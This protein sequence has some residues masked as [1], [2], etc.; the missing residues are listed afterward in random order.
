MNSKSYNWESSAFGRILQGLAE[1]FTMTDWSWVKAQVEPLVMTNVMSGVNALLYDETS[2]GNQ[3]VLRV[4]GSKAIHHDGLHEGRIEFNWRTSSNH[5]VS[6]LFKLDYFLGGWNCHSRN[7]EDWILVKM[8]MGIDKSDYFYSCF[9][10]IIKENA[11]NYYINL[12]EEMDDLLP[13]SIGPK[14]ELEEE[15]LEEIFKLRNVG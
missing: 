5:A 14:G 7:Q 2:Y 13:L 3:S 12:R 15:D 10:D 8:V 9:N 6:L 11:P 1:A 4:E